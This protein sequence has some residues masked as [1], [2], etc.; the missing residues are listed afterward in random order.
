M[1][2]FINPY[3][4]L[5]LTVNSTKEE[6]KRKYYELSLLVHPDKGGNADDMVS[7]QSA[8]KFVLKELENV[9][10]S[11]TV[12]KLEEEFKE[13]CSTQ[14]KKVP[15]FQDIYA[16]A[17]DLPKFNEY[18]N[19]ANKISTPH[20]A[21][22]F[23]SL[24]G[25]Y[26]DLMDKSESIDPQKYS[27]KETTSVKNQFDAITVYEHSVLEQCKANNAY[28]LTGTKV[29]NDFNYGTVVNGL[30]M[31]DYKEAFT[32]ANIDSITASNKDPNIKVRTLEDLQKEREETEYSD[33]KVLKG[34]TWSFSGFIDSTRKTVANILH[35]K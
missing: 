6:A 9:D 2:S 18:F 26:G 1:S 34:Y 32:S 17:F 24:Q 27:D 35:I 20:E 15:E 33:S 23:A 31:A 8:Y 11:I 22:I 7:L 12:E 13:F 4:L 16:D 21:I 25:G 29:G 28:S 10:N 14:E 30:Y 19:A 3:E 5:G